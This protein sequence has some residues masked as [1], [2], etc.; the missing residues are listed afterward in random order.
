L[1]QQEERLLGGENINRPSTKFV[2]E[3]HLAVQIKVILDQQPLRVRVGRL[4]NE[5]F[6]SSDKLDYEGYHLI[7]VGFEN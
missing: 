7:G 2:F 5:W 4:Q 1:E 3:K 6:D